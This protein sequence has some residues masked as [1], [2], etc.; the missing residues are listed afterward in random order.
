MRLYM[1]GFYFQPQSH[2]I[3]HD[4]SSTQNVKT[5]GIR[6]YFSL[7]FNVITIKMLFFGT[8]NRRNIQF[9]GISL[10]ALVLNTSKTNDNIAFNDVGR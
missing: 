6:F 2:Y 1:L 3:V 4:N 10:E 5:S 7:Y 8:M 9:G